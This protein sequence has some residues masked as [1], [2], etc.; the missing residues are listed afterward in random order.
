MSTL[1]GALPTWQ[2]S[3]KRRIG[4]LL[5]LVGLLHVELQELCG[6]CRLH[7]R[8][9]ILLRHCG[10]VRWCILLKLGHQVLIVRGYSLLVLTVNACDV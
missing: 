7:R 6:L 8:L 4:L 9:Q 10:V 2:L 3:A 5:R 1:P